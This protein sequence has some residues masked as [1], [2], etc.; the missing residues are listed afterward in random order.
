V[1]QR[2]S[3]NRGLYSARRA[4]ASALLV[5][6][7]LLVV[8][9]F[10]AGAQGASEGSP[11][12]AASKPS[13]KE[14]TE[15]GEEI[16]GEQ[17]RIHKLTKEVEKNNTITSAILAPIAVLV[18]ILALGGSLGI[19]FSVRDQ[20]RVSQLHELTV[21][22]EVLTQ[23]RAEQSYA[24]F[25]EQ[26]QTTLS[27]VNDTLKLAKEANEQATHSMDQRAK[28][29]VAA[30]GEKGDELLEPIFI[31]G[32]FEEILD[33]AKYRNAVHA[34]GDELQS[35]EGL[36]RL[37]G[38]TLPRHLK[39]IKALAQFL[40][41]DTEGALN[42]LRQIAYD[43][44]GGELHHFILFW[45]GYLS[46]TVGDYEEAV[47][48]FSEDESGLQT[49]D[50]E[51]FQLDCI[52]AETH[53]FERAKALREEKM[54][55]D[56]KVPGHETPLERLRAVAYLLDDLARVACAVAKSDDTRHR[57][58]VSLEVART[59]ADIYAWIAY[60]PEHL[61]RALDPE[62]VAAVREIAVLP[63][64][65]GPEKEL[66]RG[67][68]EHLSNELKEQIDSEEAQIAGAREFAGTKVA[69]DLSEDEL[70]AWALIQGI[71]IC[72]NQHHRNFDVNFAQAECQYL[73][74]DWQRGEVEEGEEEDPKAQEKAD[75]RVREAQKKTIESALAAIGGELGDYVEQRRKV[76]LKQGELVCHYR[77]LSLTGNPQE[78]REINQVGS[79]AMEEAGSLKQERVT[80]F[81]QLQR[82]N[83]TREEFLDE[84]KAIV[85]EVAGDS[86]ETQ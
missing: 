59:R 8:A 5:V 72:Q 71:E 49:D 13:A 83:L 82:R 78:A 75:E 38:V 55:E 63:N 17:A 66:I 62:T 68:T 86:E 30:I 85:K 28:E 15:Q 7:L 37:Q 74:G 58:H 42:A 56:S 45:L 76:S 46:T 43:G 73:L 52:I 54:G 51:R 29:Q 60:D 67:D 3:S 33:K 34:I 6:L 84:V 4:S 44:S 14:V 79:K 70:R 48:I 40:D 21:S 57:H 36:L 64:L 80:I 77:L 41:D 65:A 50:T 39:F 27:L 32:D 24:S 25:F 18:G 31:D 16:Q 2:V 9:P 53:F 10:A 23:R 1:T 26:S 20:R 61:D 12:P 35:V 69:E 81:S 19:V 47:R 22:G 11:S